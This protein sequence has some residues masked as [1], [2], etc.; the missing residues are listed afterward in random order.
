MKKTLSWCFVCCLFFLVACK[1]DPEQLVTEEISDYSPL[2]VG[3]YI[4][5]QLDS[6]VSRNQGASLIKVSYQVKHEVSAATTDNNNRPAYRI[7]RYIRKAAPQA[8]VPDNSFMAI[9]TGTSLEF[10]ENNMRFVKLRLPVKNGFSWKG[11]SYLDTYSFNSEIKYL[12]DWDYT[13]DS[14][15]SQLSVGSLT[16]DSTIKVDQRD[17][18]IG[19]PADI[20]AYSEV[21]TGTEYYAKGIGLVHR[22]FLHLEYQPPTPGVAGAYSDF[23]YGVTLTMIEHN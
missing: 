18:I 23:S 1:K 6:L 3:K 10:V 16:I 2:I 15:A 22:R 8:W 7:T 5:Y 21:N 11:N 9:N 14:V 20:N 13:Y 19:N 17:E 4:I 12:T